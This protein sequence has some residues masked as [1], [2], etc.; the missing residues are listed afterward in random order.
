MDKDLIPV[1]VPLWRD[2]SPE[3][4]AA[5]ICQLPAL[6]RAVGTVHGTDYIVGPFVQLVSD[7]LPKVGAVAFG[8]MVESIP[9]F[10]V[11]KNIIPHILLL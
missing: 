6:V 8:A 11:G 7:E 9:Y 5:M 10:T 4:R 2:P 3:V 1:I